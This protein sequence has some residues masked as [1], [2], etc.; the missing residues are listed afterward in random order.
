MSNY[1][2]KKLDSTEFNLL[3]PLMKDCFGVSVNVEYF[4]WK[5]IKNPSGFVEG[6]IALSESD[7]I[8]AFY[9]VIPEVYIIDERKTTIFQSCDTMTHSNHRRKG[10]FQKLALHC[11]AH[12]AKENKLFIIGFGG[13][14]STPGFL[15]FGWI[16]IFYMKFYFYPK[17]FSLFKSYPH[18]HIKKIEDLSLI[19]ELILKS[20]NLSVIHSHKT[21][22]NFKWRISN[23]NYNYKILAY[24]TSEFIYNSFL[25]YYIMDNKIVL[26]DFYFENSKSGKVLVG[27]IKNQLSNSKYKGIIAFCQENSAFSS[28]LGKLGFVSNPFSIGP[29][30]VKVPFI[31]YANKEMLNTYNAKDKWLVNSFDHDAM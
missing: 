1:T 4:E 26:F 5:Y 17:I 27:Q 12:L 23:P 9:G 13:G 18:D 8:A 2:I 19:E 22:E 15:K 31:F 6:F 24:Q 11:Y 29:L 25:C 16:R 14:Q 10:L 21:L 7:E 30:S 20:N 3:I 28:S